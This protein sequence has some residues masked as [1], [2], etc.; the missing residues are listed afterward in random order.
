VEDED[1][2]RFVRL[3]EGQ[4]L[5]G[6]WLEIVRQMRDMAGFAHEPLT[7]YMKRLAERWHEQRGIE[8]PSTDPRSFLLAAIRS[9]LLTME[10]DPYK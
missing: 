6:T 9:G 4:L 1:L 7:Q 10:E 2:Q 3:P 5:R 8:V